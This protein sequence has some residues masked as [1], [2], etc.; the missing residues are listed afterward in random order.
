MIEELPDIRQTIE[1]Y[2]N[3]QDIE[4]LDYVWE[5]ADHF[6][7]NI[8]GV[9]SKAPAIFCER[10]H[11]RYLPIEERY[12]R[13][14][15][16]YLSNISFDDYL[17]TDNK[18]LKS[19]FK[20]RYLNKECLQ[21]TISAFGLDVSKLWY[22]LLFVH[23]Y[24]EDLGNNSPAIGKS[25]LQDFND[26]AE[27]LSEA[28]SIILKKSNRKSYTVEKEDT[29]KIIQVAI[30]HYIK[31]YNEIINSGDV[32][33]LNEINS[34]IVGDACFINFKDRSYLDISYKKW[35]FAEIFL[36]FL[37]ERK[38]IVPKNS[39]YNVSKDRMLF[40]SR[41]IYTVGYDGK[42]YNESHDNEGN[43]N[44]MLSNLLRRYMKEDFPML[45]AGHYML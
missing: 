13:H 2:D 22:L 45:T 38:A 33:R 42:R 16:F 23:D 36:Y 41:L 35:K 19:N 24:I 43:P 32:E 8:D 14:K 20:E 31:S 18:P 11:Q 10:Y 37:K 40:I 7:P 44:R 3:Y 5:V 39:I 26:F 4:L 25:T 17:K 15:N 28:T 12:E 30:Q 27:K 1:D 9:M 34:S 21:N 29:I 6:L